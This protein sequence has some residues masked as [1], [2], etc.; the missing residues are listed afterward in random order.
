MRKAHVGDLLVLWVLHRLEAI[1][2]TS[3]GSP[4]TKDIKLQYRPVRFN[5]SFI[6]RP[7]YLQDPSPEVDQAWSDLGIDC[8]IMLIDDTAALVH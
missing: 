5:G 8:A 1:A 2:H 3:L 7:I 6:E 4:I